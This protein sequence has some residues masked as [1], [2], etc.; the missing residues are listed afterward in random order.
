M[1]QPESNFEFSKEQISQLLEYTGPSSRLR[2]KPADGVTFID[3]RNTVANE[4]NIGLLL[5][6]QGIPFYIERP[7][8][9]IHRREL[10]LAVTVPKENREATEQLLASAVAA[11][12]VERVEGIDDLR[13]R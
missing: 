10:R 2:K 3:Y 9:R 12:V 4:K 7:K 8:G 1:P 13:T 11:A 6:S 5:S